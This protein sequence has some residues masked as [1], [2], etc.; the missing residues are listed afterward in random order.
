MKGVVPALPIIM[1]LISLVTVGVGLPVAYNKLEEVGLIDIPEDN[2]VARGI[3]R[4]GEAIERAFTMDKGSFDAKKFA[5]REQEHM[6]YKDKEV[7]EK[8]KECEK[9]CECLEPGV[10]CVPE[11]IP[12][13]FCCEPEEVK[14]EVKPGC[15][16]SMEYE[17]VC[18]D[19]VTYPNLCYAKCNGCINYKQGPCETLELPK[20]P[21]VPEFVKRHEPGKVNP[22]RVFR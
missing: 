5:E 13:T 19:G 6:I 12:P 15:V 2:I 21:K 11:C 1:L 8:P 10:V 14:K 3:E 18:C 9:W 7:C 20:E 22:L 16:C 17:P 4:A